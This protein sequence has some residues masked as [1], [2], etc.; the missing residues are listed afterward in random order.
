[1]GDPAFPRLLETERLNIRPVEPAYA[2]VINAAVRESFDELRLWLPWAD[3][4]PEVAE[5]RAHLEEQQRQFEAGS[6]CTLSLWLRTTGEFV[7][8]SGLHPRSADAS[9]REIGY[10]VHSRHAGRG[11]ATE[12]VAAI[13]R[14]GFAVLGLTAI[15]IRA[16]ERNVASQ[17]V[18]ERAGFRREVLLED[19]RLDPDGQPSRTVLYVRRSGDPAPA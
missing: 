9:R 13:A 12:A 19:G 16:S 2:E 1:M 18:A 3:H 15:E 7:G 14:T 8:S 17:R 11:L 6:D 5:T 10:W 4:V